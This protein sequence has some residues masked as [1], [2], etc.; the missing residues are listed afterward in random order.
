MLLFY[1]NSNAIKFTIYLLTRLFFYK[2]TRTNAGFLLD[3]LLTSQGNLIH[4]STRWHNIN[5]WNNCIN[6]RD[7]KH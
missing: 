5:N 3:M 1:I 2:K 4:V 7:I 6:V